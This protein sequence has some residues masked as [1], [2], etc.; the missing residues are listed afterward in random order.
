[1]GYVYSWILVN[2]PRKIRNL[3]YTPQIPVRSPG[4]YP[5]EVQQH[6]PKSLKLS[7]CGSRLDLQIV[8]Q[9][10][11]IIYTSTF[12]FILLQKGVRT[13]DIQW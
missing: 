11:V 2:T 12:T 6:D 1:M 13:W 8:D 5:C 10:I 4:H 3:K 9:Q 7:L